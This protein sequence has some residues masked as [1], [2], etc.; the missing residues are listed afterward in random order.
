MPSAVGYAV[1]G[2]SLPL[3]LGF[4]FRVEGLTYRVDIH[5]GIFH[6]RSAG[7]MRMWNILREKAKDRQGPRIRKMGSDKH[8]GL[9]SSITGMTTKR[10]EFLQKKRPNPALWRNGGLEFDS[11]ELV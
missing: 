3:S 7:D 4:T 8:R 1:L 6:Q 2:S 10:W 9:R 5:G 11:K